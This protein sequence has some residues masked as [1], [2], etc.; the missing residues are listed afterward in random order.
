VNRI[1]PGCWYELIDAALKPEAIEAP[2]DDGDGTV[3]RWRKSAV[4]E[5]ATGDA[6][7]AP[8]GMQHAS[9]DWLTRN[10]PAEKAAAPAIA[11]SSAVDYASARAG[12]SDAR[13][14]MRGRIVHQLLQ[15]LPAVAPEHRAGAAKKPFARAQVFSDAERD[16][17][18]REVL[19]VLN[20]GRFA[21]LFA[22]GS[23]AEVPI[24]G[25]VA[26]GRKVS[27]QVDRLAVT[28]S[29][30]L[31][32]DYKSDRTVPHGLEDAPAGHIEQLA[33]YRA[34]LRKLYPNHMVRAALVWT[35]GPRLIELP[36][37]VLDAALSR[38][39][40]A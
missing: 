29:E 5:I 14:L 11:P 17:I 19:G 36:A 9:P 28:E 38:V 4:E 31:I 1:P 13:G 34:V 12:K 37:S 22:P 24:V 7:S 40:Q 18:I 6:V 32:A 3:W 21:S 30:V 39:S 15:A 2:A 26:D 20:D 23:R 25:Y 35:L 27:G 33:L 8:A 16:D 10:A